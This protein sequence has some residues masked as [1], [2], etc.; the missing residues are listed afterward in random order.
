MQYFISK[1]YYALIIKS[2][3]DYDDESRLNNKST[4]GG[5]LHQY[6]ILTF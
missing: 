2:Q 3:G 4:H 6:G 1:S 5:H